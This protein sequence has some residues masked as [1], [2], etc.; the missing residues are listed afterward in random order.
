MNA[1]PPHQYYALCEEKCLRISI[2]LSW[3]KPW[4]KRI[5]I[6]MMI[7]NI[8]TFRFKITF[9]KELKIFFLL[10]N[11]KTFVKKVYLAEYGW[12]ESPTHVCSTWCCL[13]IAILP[14]FPLRWKVEGKWTGPILHTVEVFISQRI[15]LLLLLCFNRRFFLSKIFFALLAAFKINRPPFWMAQPKN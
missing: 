3:W 15:F 9:H 2:T 10:C 11:I 4:W 12:K 14:S 8:A 1:F 6:R 13:V 7:P 5:F